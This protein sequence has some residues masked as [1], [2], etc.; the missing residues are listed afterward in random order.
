MVDNDAVGTLLG[1]QVEAFREMH[2]DVFL[3]LEQAENFCLIF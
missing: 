1:L 2:S 3:G